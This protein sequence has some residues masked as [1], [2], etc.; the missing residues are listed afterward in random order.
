MSPRP[1]GK[2][3]ARRRAVHLRLGR[4]GERIAARLLAE[5]GFDLLVRNYRCREGEIDL[6]ARENQVLCFVEVK[7]RR[8]AGTRRPAE[9][10]GR[11]KRRHI[12][13]AA[14][15]YLREIGRPPVP[16]RFD[17]IEVILSGG[18]LR[19]LRLHRGAFTDEEVP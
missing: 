3:F 5:L 2:T 15:R 9:A 11:A 16:H 1:S 4:R 14:H 6:V 10:V 13:R 19:N 12:I 7:T 17:I 18:V 8:R